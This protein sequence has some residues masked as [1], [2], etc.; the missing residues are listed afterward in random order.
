MMGPGYPVPPRVPLPRGSCPSDPRQRP[1]SLVPWYRR[2]PIPLNYHYDEDIGDWVLLG[3]DLMP[4]RGSI[5]MRARVFF[6]IA[7]FLEVSLLAWPITAI[8]IWGIQNAILTVAFIIHLFKALFLVLAIITNTNIY[9]MYG[10][11]TYSFFWGIWT[12]RSHVRD[13]WALSYYVV[14]YWTQIAIMCTYIVIALTMYPL[15]VPRTLWW[16]QWPMGLLSL[17]L[18][19]VS[20]VL[21]VS[22]QAIR[23]NLEQ[24]V[25]FAPHQ[26]KL[27][28]SQSSIEL[29][30]QPRVW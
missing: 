29:D 28:S 23:K 11:K 21:I 22:E 24:Y 1:V 27:P 3:K 7:M 17:F 30:E 14:L 2:E 13:S 5:M 16:I 19:W 18:G 6:A 10:R 25:A 9:K 4:H 8:W 26:R 20:W 12:R 15:D